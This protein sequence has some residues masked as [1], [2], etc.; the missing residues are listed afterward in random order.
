MII[1]SGVN[2]KKKQD[3]SSLH[4]TNLMLSIRSRKTF[5]GRQRM[6]NCYGHKVFEVMNL[7]KL[8]HMFDLNKNC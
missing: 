4:K 6:I 3:L 8:S 2:T 1:L 7:A 5:L